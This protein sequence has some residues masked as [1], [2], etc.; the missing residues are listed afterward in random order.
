MYLTLVCY[1]GGGQIVIGMAY[2]IG[3]QAGFY[4]FPF[5]VAGVVAAILLVVALLIPARLCAPKPELDAVQTA[6]ELK[7]DDSLKATITES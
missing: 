2:D 5:L 3:K 4:F 6:P 7:S 1:S